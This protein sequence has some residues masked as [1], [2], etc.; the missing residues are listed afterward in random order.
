MIDTS[1]GTEKPLSEM[2]EPLPQPLP[3][4]QAHGEG[5]KN[6]DA[7]LEEFEIAPGLMVVV[8]TRHYRVKNALNAQPQTGFVRV[9]LDLKIEMAGQNEAKVE[10]IFSAEYR[11]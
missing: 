7:A 9:K 11:P 4:S 6:G 8:D 5:S 1:R 10:N 3:T 2:K